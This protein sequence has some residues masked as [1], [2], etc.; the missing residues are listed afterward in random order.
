MPSRVL[1]VDDPGQVKLDDVV[2]PGAYASMEVKGE[3]RLDEVTRPG[4]SGS[5]KLAE[6][7]EDIRIRLRLELLPGEDEVYPEQQLAQIAR[8]FQKADRNDKPFVYAIVHPLA[9]KFGVREVLFTRCELLDSRERDS[10][11][12]QLEFR[13]FTPIAVRREKGGLASLLKRGVGAKHPRRVAGEGRG[14]E[15]GR[16]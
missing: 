4:R 13:E 6:G 15:P 7:W 2:L 8:L 9:E 14:G 1:R 16:R 10:T 11:M 3:L 12:A 5:A